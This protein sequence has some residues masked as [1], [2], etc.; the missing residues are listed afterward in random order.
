MCLGELAEVIELR[1]GGAALV[2]SDQRTSTVSLLVLDVPVSAGDWVV[3]HSGFALSRVSAE[4]ARDAAAL[5]ATIT[6]H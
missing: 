6:P 3:C 2:R 4:Q 1:P 5:R